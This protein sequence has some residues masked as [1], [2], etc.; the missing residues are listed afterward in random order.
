[1][2]NIKSYGGGTLLITEKGG[3]ALKYLSP[4]RLPKK[5]GLRC[6]REVISR[7]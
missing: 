3:K 4:F 2:N 1:M 6:K 5:G 7:D